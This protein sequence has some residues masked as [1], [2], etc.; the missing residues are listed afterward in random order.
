MNKR[1]K[2]I[3][4][5]ITASL[6]LFIL[7]LKMIPLPSTN[8]CPA[9]DNL[10]SMDVYQY[11]SAELSIQSSPDQ[12]IQVFSQMCKMPVAC[13]DDRILVELLPYSDRNTYCIHLA[14]QFEF[15][16]SSEFVQLHID[17]QYDMGGQSDFPKI[18]RWFN[19]ATTDI[20]DFLIQIEP[21]A[22]VS[23]LDPTS[24]NVSIGWTWE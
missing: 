1:D 9:P 23:D 6:I 17:I 15:S 13:R 21:F 22:A 8:D 5:A 14:R 18:S 19:T 16:D 4:S 24:L 11:L 7:L 12:I 2:F 3:I 10:E 20:E